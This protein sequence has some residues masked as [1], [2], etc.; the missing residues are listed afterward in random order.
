MRT[1]V[2]VSGTEKCPDGDARASSARR[3]P[4]NSWPLSPKSCGAVDDRENTQRPVGRWTPQTHHRIRPGC[5]PKARP[6]RNGATR[7]LT[8]RSLTQPCAARQSASPRSNSGANDWRLP[9]V[10]SL[11]PCAPE[12]HG[13]AS[14][15]VMNP[16]GCGS[17]WSSVGSASCRRRSLRPVGQLQR[18]AIQQ[19][20]LRSDVVGLADLAL[21]EALV[22]DFVHPALRKS[23]GR[24]PPLDGCGHATQPEYEGRIRP[25]TTLT[26]QGRAA[27][28]GA[29][30]PRR[31]P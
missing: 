4:S 18:G 16:S 25:K 17:R 13:V 6:S 31:R 15:T 12:H 2:S 5:H 1:V 24:F 10:C 21:R 30:Q 26:R 22:A 27:G 8:W 19:E 7:L 20:M 9:R 3:S 29:R 23:F 14:T 11:P 28:R